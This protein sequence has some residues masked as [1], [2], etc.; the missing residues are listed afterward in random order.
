EKQ[1]LPERCLEIYDIPAGWFKGLSKTDAIA[2]LIG[3][4]MIFFGCIL[5]GA[6]AASSGSV[7]LWRCEG[8]V[9]ARATS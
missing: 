9:S 4:S 8:G 1:P 6:V 7:D 3:F 5:I 2:N